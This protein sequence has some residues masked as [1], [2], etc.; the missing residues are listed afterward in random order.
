VW[1]EF[2]REEPIMT[3][4]RCWSAWFSAAAALLPGACSLIPPTL[5][6]YPAQQQ[7]IWLDQGWTADE[8]YRYHRTD[9]GTLSFGVPFEWFVALEQPTL[10][11]GEAPPLSDK[12]WLDRFGF[13]PGDQPLPVGFARAEQYRDPATGETWDN[14]A[15]GKP[16]SGLGMTCAACHT[17]R[18]T[19]NGTELLIDGGSALTN[20]G[21]FR[22]ALGQSIAFTDINPLR[23]DRF[24]ARLL[25]SGASDQAKAAPRVQLKQA[26]SLGK[27]ELALINA[28]KANSVE[29]GFGRLDAIN[30]IGN[31]VFSIDMNVDG[32]YA[33][34][35]APVHFPHIWTA[36][37]F[38]WVQYNGSIMQPMVRNAGEAMGVR[39]LV[40][41]T[42]PARPMFDSTIQ[43][44]NLHW[45]ERILA[46]APPFPAKAFSG[47]RSPSW[48][49]VLPS[50]DTARAAKGA[51]LY[52]E[53]CQGCHLPAP[54]TAEFWTGKWWTRINGKGE[55]YLNLHQIPAAD[56]GT[57]P[58]M[59]LNMAT[60]TVTLPTNMPLKST[61]F[62]PA[63]GELVER[64]TTR[65]YDSQTQAVSA[66]DRAR[67]DGDRPNNPQ[68]PL[69]YK[70]RPLNG[71][72]TAPPYLHN[73]SVPSLYALLSPVA[74]RPA[75]VYLGDREFDPYDVGYA[76]V[77]IKGGFALD[78]S[79]PGNHDTGHEFRDGPRGGGVIGRGLSPDERRALIEY[80]KTL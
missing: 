73:G 12:A 39:A 79:K 55:R 72:W 43:V 54:N 36:P 59:A 75:V 2:D 9:Q 60:R 58:A 31:Q 61:M 19:Y 70:A 7:T 34:L 35:T 16:F 52:K 11:L 26:L 56:I 6:D 1:R 62:G 5:R 40:N 71:I 29:E 44:R 17:G 49:A 23:F 64:V 30:R 65:W 18:M 33:P 51:V 22:T 78:T 57:D 28:T 24:A 37:W 74:E 53:L 63:P 4:D 50:I 76:N 77:A 3:E 46:D 10:S 13:I 66:A 41:F 67:L 68:V 14:P 48:P 32:N 15:T 27:R 8:R 80:L 20:I 69:E 42:N 21:D 45:I 38:T 25:G 47:L